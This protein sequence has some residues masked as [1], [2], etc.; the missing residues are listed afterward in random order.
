VLGTSLLWRSTVAFT[1]LKVKS[2]KCLCLLPVVLVLRIWSCLHHCRTRLAK[3]QPKAFRRI[4]LQQQLTKIHNCSLDTTDSARNLGFIFDSHL[5]FS[6]QI[7]SPSLV[8]IIFVNFAVS[9]HILTLKLPVPL[10]HLLFILNL[11]TA[12]LCTIT[13]QYLK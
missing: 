1:Y 9:A 3:R 8:I 7:S 13:F 2:A 11:I 5:T 10:P 6:E 4:S 12:T